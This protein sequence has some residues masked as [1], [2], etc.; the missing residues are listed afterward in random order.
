VNTE[1]EYNEK[2]YS[3]YDKLFADSPHKPVM[4]RETLEFIGEKT[5]ELK[6]IDATVGCGG[7]SS[8]ILMKYPEA[9]LLGLDRDE[10]ALEFAKTKLSAASGRFRLMKSRFSEIRARAT[11][12]GWL[13]VD[14]VLMDLGVSSLQ[15]DDPSRGFSHN[16]DGPLDMRMGLDSENTAARILNTSSEKDLKRIFREFGEIRKAGRLAR[17][18]VARREKMRWTSTLELA[19]LCWNI[20]GISRRKG[21][22]PPTLCFQALRMA[23]NNEMFELKKALEDAAEILAPGG[24]IAVISFHSLEDRVVKLFFRKEAS[25]CLCPPDF[26]ECRCGHK[27]SLEIVTKKPVTPMQ[28]EIEKNRRAAPAKMRIARK[29]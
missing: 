3:Y 25:T 15:L 1:S 11:D 22:P 23:V 12:M 18:I 27:P 9:V 20:P 8:L 4:P 16:F 19:E 17:E 21:P 5:G 26:P 24:I 2:S 14:A 13:S 10:K 7:H 28:D 6:V 29:L